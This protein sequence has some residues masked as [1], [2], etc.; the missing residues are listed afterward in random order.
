[1]SEPKPVPSWGEHIDIGQRMVLDGEDY[2]ALDDAGKGCKQCSFSKSS[3]TNVGCRSVIWVRTID[4]VA[5][6][7]MGENE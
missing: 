4:L 3:C 5:D 6:T 1:M 7:L 2:T